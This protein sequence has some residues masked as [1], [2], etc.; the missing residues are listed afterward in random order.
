[1]KRAFQ[2]NITLIFFFNEGDE[3]KDAEFFFN[4]ICLF[5]FLK[6]GHNFIHPF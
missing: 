5:Y 1:M 2:E 4:N 6:S 3:V